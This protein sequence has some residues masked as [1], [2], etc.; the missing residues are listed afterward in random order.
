MDATTAYIGMPG[1]RPGG[2]SAAPL[3]QYQRSIPPG[4][5][6]DPLVATAHDQGTTAKLRLPVAGS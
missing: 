5:R 3:K 1:R 6:A 4:R 2:L